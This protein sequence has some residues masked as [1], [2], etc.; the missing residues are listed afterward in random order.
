MAFGSR[1]DFFLGRNGSVFSLSGV[2]GLKDSYSYNY[3][4]L[5]GLDDMNEIMG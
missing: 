5:E 1:L 2:R 4:V 3:L